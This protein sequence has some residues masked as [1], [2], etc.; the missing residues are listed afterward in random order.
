MYIFNILVAQRTLKK[1]LT[2]QMNANFWFSEEHVRVKNLYE[3]N[4]D[5]NIDSSINR[6]PCTVSLILG[7]DN[8]TAN[9]FL[10]IHII[11]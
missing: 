10:D 2:R 3:K 6:L 4:N 5:T 7:T 11:S 1:L 8:I 9:N